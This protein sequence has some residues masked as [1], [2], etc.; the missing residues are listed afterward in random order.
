MGGGIEGASERVEEEN[1][2]EAAGG[3]SKSGMEGG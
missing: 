2:G 1:L 3:A